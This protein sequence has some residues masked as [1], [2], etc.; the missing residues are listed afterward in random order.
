MSD[1]ITKAVEYGAAA[2]ATIGSA[3]G[4]VLLVL[5]GKGVD[6]VAMTSQLA[7][8]AKRTEELEE[9]VEEI[10]AE[11]KA[12]RRAADKVVE[13]VQNPDRYGLGNAALLEVTREGHRE[14]REELRG[15]RSDVS[16]LSGSI[17]ELVGFLRARQAS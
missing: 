7:S 8:V 13:A 5:R 16:E 11:A 15:L 9:V 17:R 14:I 4:V 10:K 2:I 1:S 12:G 6:L 3:I